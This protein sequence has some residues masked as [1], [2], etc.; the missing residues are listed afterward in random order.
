[1]LRFYVYVSAQWVRRYGGL[2]RAKAKYLGFA[3]ATAGG[4]EPGSR[5]TSLKSQQELA[6]L[7]LP[8]S[9]YSSLLSVI[10]QAGHNLQLE[11]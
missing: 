9:L 1:M 10:R 4:N 2:G 11:I 6:L 3:G 7:Q 8:P 5:S